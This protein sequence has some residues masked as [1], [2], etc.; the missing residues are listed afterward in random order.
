MQTEPGQIKKK[1]KKQ[2][3]SKAIK[4]LELELVDLGTRPLYGLKVS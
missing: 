2:V 3:K 4:E 1:A